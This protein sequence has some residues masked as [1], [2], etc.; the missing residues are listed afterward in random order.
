MREIGESLLLVPVTQFYS[1]IF[2]FFFLNSIALDET[3]NLHVDPFVNK[4]IFRNSWE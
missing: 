1:N 4:M 3:F 2:S